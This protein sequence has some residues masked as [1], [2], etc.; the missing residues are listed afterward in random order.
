V[1]ELSRVERCFLRH[2]LTLAAALQPR[3][4]L[5]AVGRPSRRHAFLNP[6][7]RERFEIAGPTPGHR[8]QIASPL[9]L[10]PSGGG[11]I[12]PLLEHRAVAL[13]LVSCIG[14][15]D[16]GER[17]DAHIASRPGVAVLIAQ[18]LGSAG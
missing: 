11:W 16:L 5:R 10:L 17:A 12:E 15:P 3:Q 2:D 18:G 14:D 4:D 9:C 6:A 13:M 8:R 7:L 1:G